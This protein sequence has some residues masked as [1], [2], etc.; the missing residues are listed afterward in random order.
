MARPGDDGKIT[1]TGCERRLPGDKEHFHRHRDAF[2]PKCKE[3]RGGSFGINDI[4]KVK[5][6][7]E[8]HKFC[9][10]C[11]RELPANDDHFFNGGKDENGLTSQCKKCQGGIEY[12]N[13]SD[14][15]RPNYGRD[16]GM[17]RCV[18]CDTVY[19][20]TSENFYSA[21]T[22]GAKDGLMAYCKACHTQ[23]SNQR[24]REAQNAVKNDLTSEE[25]GDIK[26]V[27]NDEC[28]YCGESGALERDHVVP[29]SEGGDTTK[30]NIAPACEGCNRSK[31]NKSALEWW[32]KQGHYNQSRATRL[33]EHLNGD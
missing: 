30:S 11:H 7:K 14:N 5:D 13:G 1:C 16:D 22:S 24:R 20:R 29:L 2:K 15:G 21:G 4:N 3:C 33:A 18:A 28:A 12:S 23:R 19:E 27:F 10:S 26:E 31:S 32:P 9:S 8:G 17:W 25:W 6:A